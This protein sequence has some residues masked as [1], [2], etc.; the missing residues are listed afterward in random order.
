MNQKNYKSYEKEKIQKLQQKIDELEDTIQH[1]N[2]E[3]LL[4]REAK[5]YPAELSK[6]NKTM[7]P[8]PRFTPPSVTKILAE[9]K[10][11]MKRWSKR[12]K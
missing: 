9:G 5:D 3:L 8:L 12:K 2:N 6:G 7:T 1:L 4:C 11:A 10:K